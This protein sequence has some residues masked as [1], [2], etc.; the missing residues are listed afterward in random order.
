MFNGVAWILDMCDRMFRS[1]VFVL[2]LHAH[3]CELYAAHRST[4][5]LR[6]YT[7]IHG[8]RQ[9]KPNA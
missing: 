7:G 5:W 4:S 6:V 8:S 1:V 3:V 2:M 9:T